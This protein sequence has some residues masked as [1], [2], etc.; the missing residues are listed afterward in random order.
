MSALSPCALPHEPEASNNKLN[1]EAKEEREVQVEEWT[2]PNDSAR[3]GND[4]KTHDN[5]EEGKMKTDMASFIAV[6]QA[7]KKRMRVIAM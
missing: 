1:S 6:T 3:A 2:A 7:T 5:N 4:A